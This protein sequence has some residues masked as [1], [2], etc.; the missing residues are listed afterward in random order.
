[1]KCLMHTQLSTNRFVFP[2]WL[3]MVVHVCN[4]SPQEAEGGARVP[5]QAE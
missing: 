4:T 3:G 1:M 5:G 2:P